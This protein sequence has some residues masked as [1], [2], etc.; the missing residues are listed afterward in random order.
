MTFL[1][2]LVCKLKDR[3]VSLPR[4]DKIHSFCVT[5]VIGGLTL[6]I[7]L[8]AMESNSPVRIKY[9]LLEHKERWRKKK[10]MRF[11]RENEILR[12]QVE[13]K[14]LLERL[15]IPVGERGESQ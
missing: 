11:Q 9:A 5:L 12:L 1:K 6:L 7:V 14:E 4:G 15:N 2:D 13:K 10:V 8:T 3:W